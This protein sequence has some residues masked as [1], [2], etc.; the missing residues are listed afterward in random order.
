MITR[1]APSPSG[2]LH[3]GHAYAARV[4]YAW[5]SPMRLRIEDIDHVV[6]KTEFTTAIIED[7][8]WL[9][10]EFAPEITYQQPKIPRYQ[11]L[12]KQLCAEGLL[13]PC[14]CSRTD[15]RRAQVARAPHGLGVLY[16]G[17]CRHL[18]KEQQQA[19]ID[20][21]ESF[22]YRI[23]AGKAMQRVG[24]SHF[25]DYRFG[26]QSVDMEP[27]GDMVIARKDG[28]ISYHLAVICD[29]ADEDIE[30]VTRGEDLL[31]LT[32]LHVVLQR[33]LG[34]ETPA[35]LHHHLVTDEEGRRL[36]KRDDA[37]AVRSYREQGMSREEFWRM[38][39]DFPKDFPKLSQKSC[40]EV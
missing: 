8:Q 7:M 5:G 2:L 31:A 10:L 38:L 30:L 35:Y 33:L 32:S 11:A 15:I 22:A 29:D 12:V 28:L 23:D 18:R 13:Y 19:R 25:H 9:G 37:R 6:C 16:P 1:F 27:L 24:G 39:P 4:A 40:R 3:K 20:K 21:G 26:K 36:A 14:F 34:F 17:T